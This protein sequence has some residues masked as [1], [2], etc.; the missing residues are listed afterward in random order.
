MFSVSRLYHVDNRTIN[1]Y[2]AVGGMRI[3]RETELLGES[4]L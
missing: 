4:L 3:D 1:E 2:G